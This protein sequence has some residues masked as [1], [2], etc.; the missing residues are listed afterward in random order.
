[1]GAVLG[2][3]VATAVASDGIPPKS[4]ATHRATTAPTLKHTLRDLDSTDPVVRDRAR[5]ALL[6]L[7]RKDLAE[8]RAAVRESL[9]LAPEQVAVLQQ[10]VVHVALV[11]LEYE[12]MPSGFLGIRLPHWQR[13]EDDALADVGRGVVVLSRL[14]GF[15]A[16]RVLQ[17]GD[18]ILSATI[19][20]TVVPLNSAD[21]LMASVGKLKAGETVTFEVARNGGTREVTIRLD[22]RPAAADP[23]RGDPGALDAFLGGRFEEA[24]KCWERDFLPLLGEKLG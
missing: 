20:G 24:A 17:D 3:G 14:P 18:V 10:V 11:G 9:P 21:E 23:A 4:P 15:C 22:A 7:E 8:L 12:G 1:M 6:A 2:G 5:R 13:A 16:Y 19:A